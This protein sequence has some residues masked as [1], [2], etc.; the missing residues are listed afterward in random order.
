MATPCIFCAIADQKVDAP[1]AY[2]DEKIAVFKDREPRGRV[3]FL[4]VSCMHIPS[5][6][7]L[8]SSDLPLLEHMKKAGE[9]CYQDAGE[10]GTPH[11]GF[12]WPP[13]NS[14]DHLHLHVIGPR[15]TMS[16]GARFLEFNPIFPWFKSVDKLI[17]T[18][19]SKIN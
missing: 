15:E 8:T 3:H 19:K 5:A 9:Q 4:V 7:S 10:T 17:D 11:L 1:L 14:I 12:H 16:F 18:L 6:K 2:K 13:F